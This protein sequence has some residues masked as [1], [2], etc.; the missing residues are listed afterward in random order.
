[1][2]LVTLLLMLSIPCCHCPSERVQ[3][4][5]D[6]N[7]AR[8][9][10]KKETF[11]HFFHLTTR[12]RATTTTTTTRSPPP[13]PP[14]TQQP[15]RIF[16]LR[17]AFVYL[18]HRGKLIKDIAELFGVGRDTVSDAVQRY[19]ETN[20]NRNRAGSGRP[21][22]ATDEEHVE[23][24]RQRIEEDSTNKCNSIRKL[25]TD[26]D[27]SSSSAH[28]ILVNDLNLY[29]YKLRPRQK[30]TA[31]HRRKRKERCE[32]MQER[33]GEDGHRRVIWS[34]EKI[35]TVELASN[36]H[37]DRIWMTDAP[38]AEEAIVEHVQH[39]LQL[40]V[41][42]AMGYGKKV[43][44]VFFDSD[45]RLNAAIYQESVL[46]GVLRPWAQDEF[47]Y[48]GGEYT[49]EWTFQ[50]DGAT[51]HTARAT[52]DWCDNNTN[53]PDFIN[54]DQWPPRSPDLNPLDYSIWSILLSRACNRPHPDLLSLRS[55]LER[56]WEALDIETLK[57]IVDDFPRRVDACIEAEGGHFE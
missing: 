55:A 32:A 56:E 6:R 54:K 18:Y 51:I 26:L 28:R 12:T 39:P 43:P 5:L 41:W 30:L 1:M 48:E 13:P 45:V 27:I 38:E 23:E 19:Y 49:Q 50:Q 21:R 25:A 42:A 40:H 52:Q 29:P 44:L 16:E 14:V 37:N 11:R 46:E 15:I 35:F 3:E 53:I 47:G 33:F 24:V 10:K 36:R 22:S 7:R 2:K 9:E 8:I 31:E 57:R 4:R 17:P 34:D 20:S